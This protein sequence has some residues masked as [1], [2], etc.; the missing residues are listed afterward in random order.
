MVL[1][2]QIP[3]QRLQVI[4]DPNCNNKTYGD[5]CQCVILYKQTLDQSNADKKAILE[6]TKVK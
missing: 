5:V 3:L 2:N 1:N 4:E 6:L